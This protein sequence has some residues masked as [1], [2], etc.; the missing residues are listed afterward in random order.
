[1]IQATESLECNQGAKNVKRNK[2]SK[3]LNVGRLSIWVGKYGGSKF[4]SV[5]KAKK[6]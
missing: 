2:C 5:Q 4:Q 1:M 3:R 6:Y